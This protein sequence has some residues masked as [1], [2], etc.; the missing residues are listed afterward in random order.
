MRKAPAI[1]AA[2]MLL[3]VA[4]CTPA[5]KD[6]AEP[7]AASADA[8]NAEALPQGSPPA[9]VATTGGQA[10]FAAIV[11]AESIRLVGTEPF[12][13]GTLRGSELLYST[14]ENQAGESIAVRRFAGNNGLGFSGMRDGKP[15]D[16]TITP[17]TCSDG[18]SDRS[19]PFTATLKLGEE[20]RNGCAWTDRMPFS[21]TQTP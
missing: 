3:S 5:G 21:G 18:M 12:W 2:A 11:P 8:S 19:Y 9:P 20:Q 6:S 17:G 7:E 13:G 10:P 1:T 16:L 14:P 4:G 15:F